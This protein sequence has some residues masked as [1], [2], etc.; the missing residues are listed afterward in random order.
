MLLDR[1]MP[2]WDATRAEHRVVNAPV[3]VVYSAAMNTDFMDTVRDSVAVRVLFQTRA[4]L[5]RIVS[6]LRPQTQAPPPA[7]K[8]LRLCDL[9]EHG[10][11]VRLGADPPNEIAFGVVG[12][13]WAGETK[14][15][16]IDA[17]EFAGFNRP[18][19]ARIGCNLSVRPYGNSRTL[20]TYEA[21]TRATDDA[22][23][24]AFLRYWRVV[25]P[26]VG[27][28]MRSTLSAISRNSESAPVVAKAS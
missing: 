28:V 22:S 27:V 12:R 25:S 10:E 9:P 1:L 8:T 24:R 2:T 4:G 21:R 5:E 14:W 18:G 3:S 7:P 19:F 6:V 23:R 17:S 11:W 13:F 26:F 20:L 15:E 16:A